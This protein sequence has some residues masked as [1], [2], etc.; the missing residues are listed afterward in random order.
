MTDVPKSYGYEF[1]RNSKDCPKMC[2]MKMRKPDEKDW[3]DV[4]EC[5]IY[6]FSRLY[7]A[8]ET[9]MDD[10]IDCIMD[11]DN[12]VCTDERYTEEVRAYNTKYGIKPKK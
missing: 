2:F 10:G 1:C 8:E 7:G 12:P 6:A 3:T 11:P 4:F 9:I 5:P